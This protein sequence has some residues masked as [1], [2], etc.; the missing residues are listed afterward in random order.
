[1]SLVKCRAWKHTVL[2]NE[3]VTQCKVPAAKTKD[4]RI[5]LQHIREEFEQSWICGKC[6]RNMEMH[7]SSKL[8]LRHICQEDRNL[9]CREYMR[10]QEGNKLRYLQAE[11]I[12]RKKGTTMSI[13]SFHSNESKPSPVPVYCFLRRVRLR[14]SCIKQWLW[15]D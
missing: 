15:C 5:T 12:I 2:A 3:N 4:V 13:K 14:S 11:V 1:M 7:S 6:S 8:N 10:G 9:S